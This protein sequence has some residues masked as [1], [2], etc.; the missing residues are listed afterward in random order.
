MAFFKKKK[1]DEFSDEEF[2]DLELPPLPNG[3]SS[4]PNMPELPKMPP[5]KRGPPSGFQDFGSMPSPINVPDMNIP[6]RL[7]EKPK[8]LHYIEDEEK[9]KEF[10]PVLPDNKAQVFV[11]IDKYR[12][13]IKTIEA[14]QRKMAELHNTLH[15]IS[16][17]KNKEAE[18]IE[19]WAALLMEAKDKVDEVNSKL[20]RPSE[21]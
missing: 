15:K 16:A 4:V 7:E 12:Q 13:A 8:M 20:L 10:K 2:D 3:I 9:P 14:M 5:M 18:I 1:E 11:R 6:R 17:I 21:L 19:G